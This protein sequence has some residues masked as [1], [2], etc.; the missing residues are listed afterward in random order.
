MGTPL[1]V[2]LMTFGTVFLHFTYSRQLIAM[3]FCNNILLYIYILS[4][5][6]FQ[7]HTVT[8]GG[9]QARGLIGVEAAGL[10]HSNGGSEPSLR[11]TPQLMATLDP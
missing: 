11:P 6:L 2:F 1:C 8:Y 5:C 4:F 10:R 7:G 9:S 3:N